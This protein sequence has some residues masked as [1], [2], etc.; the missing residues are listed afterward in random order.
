MVKA[1]AVRGERFSNT[2]KNIKYQVINN[3][4]LDDKTQIRYGCPIGFV[5]F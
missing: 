2:N 4:T 3:E 5:D 1:Q